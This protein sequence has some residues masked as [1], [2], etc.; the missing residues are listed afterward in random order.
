[1]LAR[2]GQ[3]WRFLKNG[4]YGRAAGGGETGPTVAASNVWSHAPG[5]TS[6]HTPGRG[7]YRYVRGANSL[8]RRCRHAGGARGGQPR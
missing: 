2:D 1:M 7:A 4:R 6:T 3:G 8:A 5:Y